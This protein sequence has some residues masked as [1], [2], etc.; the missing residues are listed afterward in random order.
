MYLS[1]SL[2]IYIYIYVCIYIYI[3]IYICMYVCIYIYIY[4]LGFLSLMVASMSLADV[5]KVTNGVSTDGDHCKSRVFLTRGLLGYSRYP[6]FIFPK[7][8]R[9][10][11]FPQPVE[12]HYFCSGLISVDPICPQPRTPALTISTTGGTASGRIRAT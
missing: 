12:I 7:S 8:A 3:Y 4:I 9:A 5:G 1:L 2:Y 10:Y 11:L 6:T